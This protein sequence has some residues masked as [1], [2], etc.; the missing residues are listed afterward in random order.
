MLLLEHIPC[1][2]LHW[3][4]TLI[5][6]SQVM[7][8][9]TCVSKMTHMVSCSK[10]NTGVS[11]SAED[12]AQKWG[13]G[14]M[15]AWAVVMCPHSRA[16]GLWPNSKSSTCYLW[17]YGPSIKWLCSSLTLFITWSYWYLLI[18]EPTFNELFHWKRFEQCWAY[19]KY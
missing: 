15:W 4:P 19:S 2:G 18:K 1:S 16:D 12:S 10:P 8:I 11:T 5:W 17:K 13:L 9:I 6:F 14:T 3:D 7:C